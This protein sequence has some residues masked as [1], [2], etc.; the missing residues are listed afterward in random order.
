MTHREDIERQAKALHEAI[1]K[2]FAGN[3]K[4]DAPTCITIYS[5]NDRSSDQWLLGD[6]QQD[7]R[8]LAQ[9][10]RLCADMLEAWA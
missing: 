9:R 4:V 7:N 10:L 2:L 8:R 5:M 6:E 1:G 3:A